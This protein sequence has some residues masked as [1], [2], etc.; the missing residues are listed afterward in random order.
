MKIIINVNIFSNYKL[1][2]G[3]ILFRVFKIH[4]LIE[5]FS[6]LVFEIKTFVVVKKY[7][8]FGTQK[9]ISYI[10]LLIRV[11]SVCIRFMR[12][13]VE[14]IECKIRVLVRKQNTV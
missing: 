6:N 7:V 5:Y 3:S 9:A 14:F 1:G 11:I 8:R 2:L 12:C 13:V 10:L 4:F